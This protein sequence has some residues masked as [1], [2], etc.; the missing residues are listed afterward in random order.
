VGGLA[1]RPGAA[2]A[3]G[4]GYEGSRPQAREA[5]SVPDLR[6]NG[7]GAALVSPAVSRSAGARFADTYPCGQALQG[8]ADEI[9]G[10]WLGIWA[11]CQHFWLLSPAWRKGALMG[12]QRWYHEPT[13]GDKWHQCYG[14][15]SKLEAK[16]L[17]KD[18]FTVNAGACFI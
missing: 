13:H 18:S 12:G 16:C 6:L 4:R 15:S 2:L 8:L 10:G 5:M 3:G 1:G 17:I 11:G 7:R 14:K 9:S